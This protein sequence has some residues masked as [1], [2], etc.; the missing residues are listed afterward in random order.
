LSLVS[1]SRFYILVLGIP[2]EAGHV[3]LDRPNIYKQIMQA[4]C[5]TPK[6][7]LSGSTHHGQILISG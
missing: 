1:D 4:Q 2:S 6:L 7:K 3:T 5:I